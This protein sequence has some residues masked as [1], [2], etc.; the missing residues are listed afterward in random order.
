MDPAQAS[1]AGDLLRDLSGGWAEV[2]PVE[3]VRE[4]AARLIRVH[5]L[6]AADALQLAAASVASEGNNS[7][8]GFV[9]LDGR[10]AD[11]ASRERF[12]LIGPGT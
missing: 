10:L 8:L 9:T 6:R 5:D 12:G 7:Q 1:K 2:A 11:A 3:A 4:V